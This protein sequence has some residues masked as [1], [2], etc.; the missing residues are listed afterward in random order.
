MLISEV[1]VRYSSKN[2]DNETGGFNIGLSPQTSEHLS[3]LRSVWSDSEFSTA[4]V[5]EV[6]FCLEFVFGGGEC[7]LS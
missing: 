7:T 2:A 3:S 4:L 5:L 6:M 1:L